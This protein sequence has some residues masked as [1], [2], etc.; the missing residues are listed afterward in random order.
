MH[1]LHKWP[2]IDNMYQPQPFFSTAPA[3]PPCPRFVW[4]IKHVSAFPSFV[5]LLSVGLV[6]A[7]GKLSGEELSEIKA[8]HFHR[9]I[10]NAEHSLSA[11]D[12]WIHLNFHLMHFLDF[13]PAAAWKPQ[14]GEPLFQLFVELYDFLQRHGK[15]QCSID[16]SLTSPGERADAAPLPLTLGT[17]LATRVPKRLAR[18]LAAKAV[19]RFSRE[20]RHSLRCEFEFQNTRR[21]VL[22]RD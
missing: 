16:F 10:D 8:V 17:L 14:L 2:K 3:H 21:A 7:M 11:Q 9:V 22:V 15:I 4:Q 1:A 20:H 6:D 12:F 18:T 5:R 13:L 19:R